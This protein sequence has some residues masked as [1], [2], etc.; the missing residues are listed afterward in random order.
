MGR[1]FS[2]PYSGKPQD[3]YRVLSTVDTVLSLTPVS[4]CVGAT[5]TCEDNSIR[6]T[7]GSTPTND[8]GTKLGH[9]MVAGQVINLHSGNAVKNF[10]YVNKTA[11]SD[12]AL[13]ITQYV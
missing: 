8:A 12:A 1:E 11:G 13:V 5:I 4:G 3:T 6:F 2:T 7:F 10:T 9:V